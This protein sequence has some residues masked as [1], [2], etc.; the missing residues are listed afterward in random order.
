MISKIVLKQE[1]RSRYKNVRLWSNA[2]LYF[3]VSGVNMKIY[4][5]MDSFP[6]IPCSFR[7]R[8]K[9]ERKTI[10][11]IPFISSWYKTQTLHKNAAVS[12]AWINSGFVLNSLNFPWPC[13]YR[14]K[15]QWVYFYASRVSKHISSHTMNFSYELVTFSDWI[16]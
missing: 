16:C 8:E 4:G 9:V 13:C 12:T 7:L 6:S 2:V 5:Q 14:A 11:W 1:N 15:P 3:P 10:A